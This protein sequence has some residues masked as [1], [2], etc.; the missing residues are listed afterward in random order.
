MPS[1]AFFLSAWAGGGL[2]FHMPVYYS[3]VGLSS[4]IGVAA[5]S[6]FALTGGL[7]NTMWGFLAEHFREQVLAAITMLAGASLAIG[8]LFVRD[9]IVAVLFGAAWGVAIRGEGSLFAILLVKFYGRKSYGA[10]SGVSM[11]FTL[12]GLGLGPVT[13]AW[14]REASD[15]YTNAYLAAVG[16]FLIAAVLLFLARRPV[17]NP[18]TG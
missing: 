4:G 5:V 1:K 13:I 16:P 17:K 3:E 6:L 14:L 7:A 2:P 15:S 12:V 10:I 8:V 18:A 9:P 11:Q